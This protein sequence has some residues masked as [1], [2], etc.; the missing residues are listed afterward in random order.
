MLKRQYF[1]FFAVT[2]LIPAVI[3]IQGATA[4]PLQN[5]STV[6]IDAG[7]GGRDLG[8]KNSN[9]AIEKN[10]VRKLAIALKREIISENGESVKVVFTRPGKNDATQE[11]RAYIA[12]SNKGDIYISL[13]TASGFGKDAHDLG[14]FIFEEKPGASWETANLAHLE[15]SLLLAGSIK[16]HLNI[17]Y[18]YKKFVTRRGNFIP[19]HGIDMPA[20]L[21]EVAGL[22]DPR[23]E[24]EISGKDFHIKFSKAIYSALIEYGIN[25]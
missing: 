18:P 16:E 15:Q 10:I 5:I 1:R 13:H 12:N 9:A 8:V 17:L 19:L 22:N 11:E 7:H 4:E 21:I 14:I 20:V 2:F 3:A 25:R 6:I 23:D 24:L